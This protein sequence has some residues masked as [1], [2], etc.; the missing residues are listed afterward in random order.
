VSTVAIGKRGLCED[1]ILQSRKTWN[2][3]RQ[4]CKVR[5]NISEESITDFNLLELQKRHCH[6]IHTY[7][8]SKQKESRYGA[9]WE[10]WLTSNGW[11]LGLRVQAKKIQPK[12]LSY[13]Y[14]NHLT[15]TGVRQIDALITQSA[16]ASHL[17]IPIYVFYNFWD[18]SQYHAPWPCTFRKRNIRAL[19]C[20]IVE[21]RALR[22]IIDQGKNGLKD[23]ARMMYPWSCPICCWK[24]SGN[25]TLPFRAFD[26][27][28]KVFRNITDFTYE[29][30]RFVTKEAPW[31]VYRILEGAE[32]LDEELDKVGINR[33]TVI[34]E[35]NAKSSENV[36]FT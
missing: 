26:F 21:A 11:F 7:K 34:E 9:D 27:L 19:G 5:L 25:K 17:K 29:Q 6:D 2:T 23:I 15:P 8:Y 20:G 10:W 32:S 1:F 31:Y 28:S 4:A 36:L 35:H 3:I 14:L 18:C 13:P 33:V 24:Y 22:T 12:T 30:D 16:A